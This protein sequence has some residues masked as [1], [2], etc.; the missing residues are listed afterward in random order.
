M[1]H[2]TGTVTAAHN[3]K[4]YTLRLTMLGIANLQEKHGNTFLSKLD[5][6]GD[7]MPSMRLLLDVVT[8]SLERDHGKD[9]VD[10]VALADDIFTQDPEIVGRIMKAAFPPGEATK[11]A[12]PGAGTRVKKTKA[13]RV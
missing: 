6:A 12:V 13:A 5:V 4:T 8:T 10:L 7:E 1:A 9:G 2:P 3:G 11:P